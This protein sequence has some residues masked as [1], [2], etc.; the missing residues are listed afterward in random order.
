MLLLTKLFY[1]TLL[2]SSVHAAP[3]VPR[4][5]TNNADLIEEVVLAATAVDRVKDLLADDPKNFVFNFVANV[6]K[7]GP[8]NGFVLENGLTTEVKATLPVSLD[9]VF[10]CSVLSACSNTLPPFIHKA[11]STIN[12]TPSVN[13]Q[14]LS[15]ASTAKIQ[16]AHRSHKT[17]L[18]WTQV[19]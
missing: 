7:T 6:N 14:F 19:L 4:A 17:F 11:R 16:V 1:A 8:G 5:A 10:I 3:L 13:K 2:A 12:L 9:H 15:V 18:P